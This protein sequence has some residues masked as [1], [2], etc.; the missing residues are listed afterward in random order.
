MLLSARGGIRGEMGGGVFAAAPAAGGSSGG[1]DEKVNCRFRGLKEDRD[2]FGKLYSIG[3]A[4][5]SSVPPCSGY[6]FF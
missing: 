2:P 4:N 6:M 5:N 1:N 3:Y